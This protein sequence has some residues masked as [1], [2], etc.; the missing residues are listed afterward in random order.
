M[1]GPALQSVVGGEDY[2]NQ[3]LTRFYGLHVGILPVLMIACLAVHVA[4]FRKHG[5]TTPR[6]ATGSGRFWPEQLFRDT[7]AAFLVFGL[8]TL[9]GSPPGGG[10]PRRPGRSDQRRLPGAARMVLPRALPDAQGFPRQARGGRHGDHPRDGHDRA[11]SSCL[12]STRSC[13]SVW[14]VSWP[15][16]SSSGY[17]VSRLSCPP[18]RFG[19][20]RKTA[21]SRP[22]AG[23]PTGSA[24]ELYSWP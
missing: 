20:T 5:V 15:V 19:R 1:V 4:L 21:D 17:S 12:S 18:P 11:C 6:S 22:R 10:R 16:A 2:G 13:R 24:T 14:H 8:V 9:A 7:A 23:R 3:T